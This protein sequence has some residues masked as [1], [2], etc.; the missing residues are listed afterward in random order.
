[1]TPTRELLSDVVVHLVP[2]DEDSK[3]TLKNHE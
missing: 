3:N 1:M 2:N